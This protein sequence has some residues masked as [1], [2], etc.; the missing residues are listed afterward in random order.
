MTSHNCSAS[1]PIALLSV[2][3]IDDRYRMLARALEDSSLGLIITG[4]EDDN[5]ILYANAAFL[6]MTG[7]S[8]D[9]VLGKNCRFLQG[10]D[11]DPD[12]REEIR[13][14][15]AE[16]RE[17][18]VEVLNYRKDGTSFWNLIHI[19]PLLGTDGSIKYFFGYQRDV[20]RRRVAEEGLQQAL[21]MEALGRLTGGLAHDFNNFLQ[22]IVASSELIE[23]RLRKKGYWTEDFI[24]P[25]DAS[26]RAIAK[27]SE[28]TKQLL[29]FSRRQKLSPT[30]LQ[31]NELI[32]GIQDMLT[33]SLGD[34]ITVSVKLEPELWFCQA[35]AA[36]IETTILNIAINARDAMEGEP[37]QQLTIQ[38][39]N[40]DVSMDQATDM[41]ITPGQYVDVMLVDNGPGIP[42]EILKRVLD[43]F[44]TTK[45]GKGTGLGL[46][47]AHGIARQSGGT[48]YVESVVG[49][50][51]AVH[52][53]LPRVEAPSEATAPV[54]AATA[55]K[56]PSL[57]HRVLLV[58]D[59]KD[60]AESLG[61]SLRTSGLQVELAFST[62]EALSAL[63]AK[64]FDVLISD[65][66]MPGAMDGIALAQQAI[67][68]HPNLRVLLL[69][70]HVGREREEELK[71]FTLLY[72]PCSSSELIEATRSLFEET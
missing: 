63:A 40:R 68:E 59:N 25:I 9:E 24:R 37:N 44:F 22:V 2:L 61:D 43:P 23:S 39:S 4:A 29:A 3:P 8:S 56:L 65:V 32:V 31:I 50:G 62:E 1:E 66:M 69:S 6:D 49:A 67:T 53:L 13:G 35:D 70:G 41:D 26:R 27:A 72:K 15:V 71:G 54:G 52:I 38:T 51:T 14:A 20:T 33:Q 36:Q 55:V 46:C 12:T 47:I 7:Y 45:G 28:L 60:V 30:N 48:L 21:K 58:D 57:A 19:L 17:L 11:T 18:M 64:A 34:R 42:R 10:P 16:Q 5:L